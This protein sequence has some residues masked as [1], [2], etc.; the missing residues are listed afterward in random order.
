M[1][2][3]TVYI[4]SCFNPDAKPGDRITVITEDGRV[5]RTSPAVFV[6][7]KSGGSFFETKNS[8]YKFRN[9]ERKPVRAM[10]GYVPVRIGQQ[11]VVFLENGQVVRTSDVM[12]VCRVNG[13]MEIETRNSIYR[14][15]TA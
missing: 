4:T 8:I 10:T 7:I 3:K 2:K 13:R 14:M 12:R 15:A 1:E 5:L 11:A 6:N 9:E